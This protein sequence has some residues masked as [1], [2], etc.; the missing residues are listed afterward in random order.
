MEPAT[1]NGVLRRPAHGFANWANLWA[2]RILVP[3]PDAAD[4][5][6]PVR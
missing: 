3:L 2:C 6:S 4:F 1:C 5:G